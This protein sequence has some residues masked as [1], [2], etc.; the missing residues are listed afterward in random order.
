MLSWKNNRKVLLGITGGIS[1]YKTPEILRELIRSGCEVE[2]VLTEDAE[3]FVSPMVLST[4]L[5]RKVWRQKDFLSSDEGWKIPHINL[6]DW[7]EVI[8]IAPATA[9]SISRAANGEA[10]SLLG[11]ILL[12]AKCPV[13]LFPA[14]NVNMWEHKAT[15]SNL[16]IIS[17]MGYRVIE[18]ASGELACGYS[19]KG[20]LPEKE[21]ILHEMWKSLCPRKDLAG[22]NVLITAGPTWEF[23]DPVRFLSNPSTG[24][25]GFALA[26]MAWYRGANVT[27]V[28]GPVEYAD[29]YD[30]NVIPVT[31]AVEMKEA[32]MGELSR[33][34]YIV[35]AAA[36][37]DY[38]PASMAEEKMK[39]KEKEN[40]SLELVQN[41]DIAYEAGK[42][43]RNDQV[44]VGFAAES[45]NLLQN[46]AMKMQKK[47]LDFIIVNDITASDAGFRSDN[48]TV[49]IIDSSGLRRDISGSK[50]DVA[51]LIWDTILKQK[52]I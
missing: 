51:S 50:G 46:A 23:L 25:M 12:A 6:A 37:G 52:G 29:V 43:K 13:L 41:P 45:Q 42:L 5:S 28:Q 11:A 49:N 30:L 10:R 9:E 44:L 20:R 27:V 35:K 3:K 39:R 8:L 1:A 22:K 47:N 48:N 24:K 21:V 36:V 26:R 19:A 2:V 31:S 33:S 14:M 40:L 7:A 38:R 34:D 32:V 15:Q 17:E 18:P 16:G 4:L